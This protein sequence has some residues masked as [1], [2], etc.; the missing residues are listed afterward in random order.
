MLSNKSL[1]TMVLLTLAMLNPA[2]SVFAQIETM[3]AQMQ[4]AMPGEFHKKTDEIAEGVT[5]KQLVFESEN[6][7]VIVFHQESDPAA[8]AQAVLKAA[9]DAVVKVAGGEVLSQKQFQNNG[10]PAHKFRV[11]MPK[12]G[13]EFRVSNFVTKDKFY[14]V[15]AVGTPEFTASAAINKMFESVKFVK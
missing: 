4:L 11:T 14:Q 5:Q 10:I 15:M 8:D 3:H 1:S 13:G 9:F 12:H 2:K 7:T 6:G